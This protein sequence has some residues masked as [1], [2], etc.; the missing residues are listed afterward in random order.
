MFRADLELAIEATDEALTL[1]EPA[2]D[3]ETIADA[4]ITRG[5]V[6]EWRGRTEE[7]N[8]LMSRG[9]DLALRHDLP[10]M[11]IRAHN[12]L[13]SV[14]WA[15]DR[16]EESLDH[17]EQA[18]AMTR[19]RGDRVMERQ[20]MGSKVS[21]LAALGRW[22][23]AED[24]A[25]TLGL[26]QADERSILYLSDALVG[27]ARMQVA[28]GDHAALERTMDVIALGLESTDTQVRSSC[29]TA[30]AIAV[31]ALDEPA[32][33]LELAQPVIRGEDPGS[34]RYAYA[35]AC[36]AA[37][38]LDDETELAELIAYI[39]GLPPGGAAPS[40]RA[41]A[42]RFAGLLA[43]RRGNSTASTKRLRGAAGVF[44]ELGY[45]FELGQV[46]LE[47]GETLL[48]ADRG[49]EAESLLTEAGAT[50]AGLRAEPWLD[51]VRRARERSAQLAS[52]RAP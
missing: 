43:A 42:D 3:W 9:L 34:R 49:D 5:T 28:R 12:N 52:S 41:Q 7:G 10:L 22:D 25:E 30:K 32:E 45:P 8:A 39:E 16:I 1:A 17:C 20:L 18:L 27:I 36:L 24:L 6:Q 15:C 26:E 33:A 48:D 14:A 47:H 19:A 31:Q 37:W 21:S 46:L 11:A 44:R 51:R 40:M 2:R 35:E 13:G 38:R 23:Q 50:F 4:L 29:A